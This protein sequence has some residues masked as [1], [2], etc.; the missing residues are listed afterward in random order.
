MFVVIER[1]LILTPLTRCCRMHG[2]AQ[3]SG[4]GR[5]SAGLWPLKM[6]TAGQT[7]F[8]QSFITQDQRL[9]TGIQ[10]MCFN[11]MNDYYSVPLNEES[12]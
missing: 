12:L 7:D 9:L 1:F 6:C 2:L 4:S 5:C 8:T 10:R 11:A 3:Y